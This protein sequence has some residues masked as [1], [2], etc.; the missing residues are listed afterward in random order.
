M[1]R[2]EPEAA[3]T[4][5]QAYWPWWPD[6]GLVDE[7]VDRM[8][9]AV[10]T[11]DPVRMSLGVLSWG[12]TLA[13]NNALF[14]GRP[15]DA[16]ALADRLAGLRDQHPDRPSVRADWAYA[17]AMLNWYQAGGDRSQGNRLIREAQHTYEELG[18]SRKAVSAAILIMLAAIP[19]D[20]ADDPEVARAIRDCTLL[21]QKPGT[22]NEA[23]HG[24]VLD[25][26]LRVVGGD[27]DA[28]P[29][30]LAAFAELE[31]VDGGW[32]VFWGGWGVGV[33]AELVGDRSVAAAHALRLVRFCRRSGVRLMLAWAIRGVARLS[34]TMDYP[35]ESLRLWGSA[36]HIEAVTGQPYMPLMERM[37]RPLR[38]H[39]ADALGPDAA[40]LLAEGASWS[41]AEATQAAE[42]ALLKIEPDANRLE[43]SP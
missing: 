37:D 6:L 24:R 1:R 5:I 30:C 4:L 41:V 14:L 42:E 31:A 38:Q 34:A 16:G 3:V 36:E 28:Y 15:D 17:M 22:L 29:S 12:L 19:W 18:L 25:P 39:C 33:A 11:A 21:S 23:A 13:S 2:S 7:Y 43:A 40:R 10:R 20:S 35:G 9:A 26:V 8:T 32:Y 27:R